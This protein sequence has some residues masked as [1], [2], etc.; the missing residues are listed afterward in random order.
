MSRRVFILDD[1]RNEL[2]AYHNA[3]IP[4]ANL[5][6]D[7]VTLVQN[8]EEGLKVIATEPVFDLW[9]LDHDL[10]CYAPDSTEQ[11]G[12]DFLMYSM[13]TTPEKIPLTLV[14]CS[15]N[16]VGKERIVELY[17]NWQKFRE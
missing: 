10:G 16:T 8:F 3:G 1:I 12:Y 11:N 15:S 9:V 6:N 2:G 13:Y 17:K 14:S 5:V 4:M 7:V